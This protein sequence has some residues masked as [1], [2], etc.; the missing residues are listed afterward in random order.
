MRKV[1]ALLS[2]AVIILIIDGTMTYD[3]FDLENKS[4]DFWLAAGLTVVIFIVLWFAETSQRPNKP[5]NDN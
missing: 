1:A 4:F 3:F 2:I 5:G